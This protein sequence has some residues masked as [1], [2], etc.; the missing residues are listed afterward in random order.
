MKEDMVSVAVYPR[1][2]D[3]LRDK[4]LTVGDLARQLEEQLAL[5]VDTRTLQRLTQDTPIQRADLAIAGAVATVLGVE[6]GD[7]FTVDVTRV[8]PANEAVQRDL[9]AHDSQRLSTLLA[10]QQQGPL[11]EQ[12]TTELRGLMATYALRLHNRRM[13]EWA[14]QRNIPVEQAQQEA[15]ARFADALAWWDALQADSRRQ[16]E[17]VERAK[18]HGAASG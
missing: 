14:R 6:L 18:N 3:L 10:R 13:R 4:G 15:A 7:L 1:L 5:S 12:N 16:H 9:N 17:L 11:S 2:A 8:V